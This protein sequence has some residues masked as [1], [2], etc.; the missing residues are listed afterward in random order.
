M[1]LRHLV[2]SAARHP[3][4]KKFIEV[5]KKHL[6][7]DEAK[8]QGCKDQHTLLP[9]KDLQE[10]ETKTIQHNESLIVDL[11]EACGWRLM[12]KKLLKQGNGAIPLEV[13]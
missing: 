1:A 2:H 6:L 9:S 7:G 13:D 10:N 4:V 8:M 3:E 12:S 5:Y 11:V